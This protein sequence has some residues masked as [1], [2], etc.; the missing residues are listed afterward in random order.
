[1]VTLKQRRYL[2]KRPIDGKWE[3]LESHFH[4]A[5]L[6]I[7]TGTT[8]ATVGTQ[9]S[10]AHGLPVTPDSN[11]VMILN[12]GAGV[13]YQSA[14]PDATKIYVKGTVASLAFTVWILYEKK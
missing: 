2:G 8:S 13:V 12:K 14:N 3:E 11:H 1:M 5:A 10:H 4:K 9:T 6:K 7:I